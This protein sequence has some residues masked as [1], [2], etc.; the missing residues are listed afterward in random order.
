[1][2]WVKKRRIFLG[3]E[4][5]GGMMERLNHAFR[6]MGMESDFYCMERDPFFAEMDDRPILKKYRI[7]TDKKKNATGEWE[8]SLW[9]IFQMCDILHLF[10]YV[11][12]R[13]DLFIYIYGRGIF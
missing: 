10:F 8:K 4:E 12:F 9:S 2:I 11:L 3:A 6:E 13:Y 7:H 5:L 1:M